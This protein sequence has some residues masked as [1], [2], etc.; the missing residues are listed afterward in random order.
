MCRNFVSGFIIFYYLITT[1]VTYSGFALFLFT[2]KFVVVEAHAW[3][4]G[5]MVLGR[6]TKLTIVGQGPIALAT[7]SGSGCL[8]FFSH[9]SF[10]SSFSLFGR[11]PDID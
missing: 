4:G 9:L 7:G 2:C 8:K 1:S 6:P 3:S 11:R 5:E 10:L